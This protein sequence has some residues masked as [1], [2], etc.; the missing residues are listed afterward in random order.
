MGENKNYKDAWNATLYDSNHSFVSKYGNDVIE[1]LN[2]IQGEKILDLGCGTGDLAKKLTDC[3]IDT[4]GID[5]SERMIFQAISKY[6]TIPF[7]VQDA[8][9]MEFNHDF[10]A[11]FSN[12]TLH[13]IKD[14]EGALSCIY[15][16]LKP[17]GRFVAEFGG[18]GNVQSITDAVIHSMKEAGLTYRSELFPWYFPSIAEYTT[19]MEKAG[20]RVAFAHHFDRPTKLDGEDGLKNWIIMFA[21]DFFKEVDEA[22]Q[23]HVIE[24]TVNRLKDILYSDG[25]WIADY[26]RIRVIGI[27]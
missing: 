17:G 4:V 16:S 23:Q 9:E 6:P 5:K 25:E 19:L 10:H 14:P 8:T 18:K 13:W 1:L 27:K 20:F 21:N 2:P 3:G 7:F 24:N 11:V 26:K 15:K 22:A 12:A